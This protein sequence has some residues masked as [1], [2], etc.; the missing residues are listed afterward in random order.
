[1]TP[2]SEE[3]EQPI[4]AKVS[5]ADVSTQ[6]RIITGHAFTGNYTTRFLK[7]KFPSCTPEELSACL[8]GKWDQTIK[9][10]LLDCQLH[11]AACCSTFNTQ[12]QVCTL[13]QLFNNPMQCTKTLQFLEDLQVCAKPRNADWDLG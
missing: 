5:C 1:M 7:G 10:I 3:T 13:N 4:T 6:F 11:A 8:C 12:G 2:C 9:H